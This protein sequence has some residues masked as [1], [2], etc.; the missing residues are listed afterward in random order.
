MFKSIHIENGFRHHNVT[1]TFGKGLTTITGPNESGKSLIIEF[2]RYALF[3]SRALRGRSEDYKKLKVTLDFEVLGKTY[4]VERTARDAKLLRGQEVI[5]TGTTA[6]NIKI[7]EIFGYGLDVFD[8]AHAVN[9][10]QVE[11]LGT[12]KPSE[13]KR[14]VD[15]VIGLTVLDDLI[16]YAGDRKNEFV[17]DAETIR[18]VLV[19]PEEPEKPADYQPSSELESKVTKYRDLNQERDKLAGWLAHEPEKPVNPGECEITQSAEELREYEKNRKAAEANRQ[20]LMRERA[21]LKTTEYTAEQLTE[22]FDHLDNYMVYHNYLLEIQKLPEKPEDG[23]DQDYIQVLLHRNRVH[24]QWWRKNHLWNHAK[25]QCPGCELEFAP[26]DDGL[27]TD[28]GPEPEKSEYTDQELAKMLAAL[29]AWENAPARV[30]PVEA[31]TFTRS[32]LESE[33]ARLNNKARIEELTQQL[34]SFQEL[35]DLSDVLER[36]LAYDHA[37]VT[38]LQQHTQY[39]EWLDERVQKQARFDVLCN[40]PDKLN[41][42]LQQQKNALLYEGFLSQYEKLIRVYEENINKI[43]QAKTSAEQ[44]DRARTALTNL[45]VKVKSHLVPS[46]NK[47]ASILLRQMT[48]GAR[49]TIQVD[50]DFNI[51]VDG[52]ELD[53]L[54]GSGK[55]VANLAIRIGLGQVLTNR[56]FS[57]FVGDELD[58]AMDN[59][60][61]GATAET[62]RGLSSKIAQLILIT[63]KRPEADNYIELGEAA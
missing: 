45:K 30:E 33:Y 48:N 3:G 51:L 8:A 47:V 56:V 7:P 21:G 41:Y 28:P 55:A 40:I 4:T 5:A 17:R 1:Y 58:A 31:P 6:V 16:K 63:H 10:G 46:L 23:M 49:Q 43:E 59:D 29:Q 19:K 44:Y 32:Q 24:Q 25:V 27:I 26:G 9:Q 14:M 36:R 22:M 13:R 34:D 53:T 15:S 37:M 52:Q 54:S 38:Y 57:V 39:C 12:M 11:A 2:A 60:R 18:S 20:A 50:E 61:A 42:V 35:P 62:L